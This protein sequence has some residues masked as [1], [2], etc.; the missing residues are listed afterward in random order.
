MTSYPT[1]LILILLLLVNCKTE[2]TEK[3]QEKS[4]YEQLTE[5]HTVSGLQQDLS[6]EIFEEQI[7]SLWNLLVF[8]KGGC[9]SGGQYVFEGK[10]GGEGCVMSNATSW[11]YLFSFNKNQLS[12]FLIG[13]ISAD[14]LQTKIHTCPFFEAIE[15]EVAVY[16]LQRLHGLNWYDFDAFIEYQNRHSINSLENHQVWLQEIL[17]DSKRRELL[18]AS[19][20]NIA[21]E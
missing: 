7:D 8:S 2:L 1:F 15:G 9:L 10:F 5:F 18:I 3:K 13:K 6:T 4:R 12:E 21:K 11:N 16:G 19:W 17:K 14:T 20:K